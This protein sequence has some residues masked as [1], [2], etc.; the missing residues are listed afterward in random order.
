ML[1]RCVSALSKTP[2]PCMCIPQSS[3]I[4][5]TKPTCMLEDDSFAFSAV[6]RGLWYKVVVWGEGIAFPLWQISGSRTA[7]NLF[8]LLVS[9]VSLVRESHIEHL[10]LLNHCNLQHIMHSP[11]DIVKCT[12]YGKVCRLICSRGTLKTFKWR[13]GCS[14]TW[15]QTRTLISHL[16]RR[17]TVQK[18]LSLVL[19]RVL[20]G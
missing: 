11:L 17:W 1:R 18:M 9:S 8:I 19:S 4:W 2:P 12:S 3:S 15:N 5:H 10:I 20:H 7:L 16:T 13:K 14:F 6:L